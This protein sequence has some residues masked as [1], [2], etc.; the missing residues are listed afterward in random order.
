MP[1]NVIGSSTGSIY[2]PDVWRKAREGTLDQQDIVG[3]KCAAERAEKE[4][5]DRGVLISSAQQEG[6][7]DIIDSL[8]E[9]QGTVTQADLMLPPQPP[10][11]A[12]STSPGV[13]TFVAGNARTA[14][15]LR[16][17]TNNTTNP[18]VTI[19]LSAQPLA[20]GASWPEAVLFENR[21]A[22]GTL[23][24]VSVGGVAVNVPMRT[25]MDNRMDRQLERINSN[26]QPYGLTARLTAGNR[27]LVIEWQP[28]H[29]QEQFSVEWGHDGGRRVL[30]A[31]ARTV[32]IIDG[33]HTVTRAVDERGRLAYRGVTFDTQS[34][35]NGDAGFDLEAVPS[36]GLGPTVS[37]LTS[38]VSD[39]LSMVHTFLKEKAEPNARL[40]LGEKPANM[41]RQERKEWEEMEARVKKGAMA[42][43]KELTTFCQNVKDACGFVR[44][45]SAFGIKLEF[46]KG[47]ATKLSIVDE[48]RLEEALTEGAT[49]AGG[50]R[51]TAAQVRERLVGAPRPAGDANGPSP[52]GLFPRL[53]QLTKDTKTAL[54]EELRTVDVNHIELLQAQQKAGQ[55]LTKKEQA[56]LRIYSQQ[57]AVIDQLNQQMEMM[58]MWMQMFMDSFSSR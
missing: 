11:T 45:L 30:L 50:I 55:A 24:R 26:I 9:V 5:T 6:I 19:P 7:H 22:S 36:T 17:R 25:L 40:P 4:K 10:Q 28:G 15:T 20:D 49:L 56:E 43:V 23:V 51:L 47:L 35:Q 8:D 16:V 34:I 2:S 52:D 3:P 1:V 53:L 29:A 42:K 31:G 39:T 13:A 14:A 38:V 44:D 32:D 48:R 21:L 54:E 12:R 57:Q 46:K 37:V 41:T 33:A 18:R 58:E 27:A